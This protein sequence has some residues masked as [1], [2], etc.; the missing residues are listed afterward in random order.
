LH[1]SLK[2]Y[3]GSPAPAKK[4]RTASP[5]VP[6]IDVTGTG[7]IARQIAFGGADRSAQV[8][9]GDLTCPGR[10]LFTQTDP[11]PSVAILPELVFGAIIGTVDLIDCV[12]LEKVEVQPYANGRWCW[13]L[14]NPE[15][16][17]RPV[18][19]PGNPGLF[20]VPDELLRRAA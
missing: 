17:R 1:K 11:Y 13:I 5:Q 14:D 18:P 3:S 20:E 16:L 15:P 6:A 4:D 19:L 9:A 10:H 12:P 8:L 7:N 2:F